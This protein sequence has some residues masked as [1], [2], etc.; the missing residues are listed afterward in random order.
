VWQ[1]DIPIAGKVILVHNEQGLGDMLQ[2][3][4]YIRY[5]SELGA[6]VLL[7][8]PTA[9]HNFLANQDGVYQLVIKGDNI[10]SFDYHCSLLSLPY[11]FKT[12][13][14]NV[15]RSRS[16]LQSDMQR[17]KKWTS[18]LGDKKK[19]R[20]GI[21]WSG[22]ASHVNDSRRSIA[23]SRFSQVLSNNCEFVSLQ[24][25]VRNEDMAILLKNRAIRYFGDE[26]VDFSETAALCHLMDVV[27]TVDT[28]VAHLS[29][30]LGRP[31]WILIPLLPDWRW[32]LK[33]DDSPW[34][35]TVKLYRQS[36]PMDWNEP[37][38]RI[39]NDLGGL[40]KSSNAS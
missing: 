13:L 15:P 24:N 39:C 16:Y 22:S 35:P 8:V 5:I 17:V 19:P 30:A 3:C 1:G 7:E 34:Y 27:V 25:E 10:P 38:R 36:E 33:R 31:T 9:L 23:L 28:S 20:I 37:L 14:L 12:D 4:R 26:L 40:E 21:A 18:L 29:A 2:F 6:K 32:M 11:I